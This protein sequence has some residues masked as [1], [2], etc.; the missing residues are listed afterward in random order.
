MVLHHDRS[1]IENLQERMRLILKLGQAL[2]YWTR[3]LDFP[4]SCKQIFQDIELSGKNMLEIGCGKGLFCIWASVQGANQVIGLEPLVKG[5]FDSS[6]IYTEFKQMVHTLEL[7]NID[8]LALRMQDYK[9]DNR[10]FDIVLSI[11]S[12][13][14]LDEDSCICLR[15]SNAAKEKYVEIFSNIADQMKEGAKLIILDCSNNNFFADIGLTNP[16]V[17]SIEWFKHQKP[18]LWAELLSDCGFTDPKITWPS[19]RYLRYMKTYNRSKLLSYF[20]D[21]AFRLEMTL[22]KTQTENYQET[23][24]NS[25][26]NT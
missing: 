10:Y 24:R 16:M 15:E 25:I 1:G 3:G 5:S 2:G 19:G 13:N 8:L 9:A 7:V 12:I 26:E 23:K 22:R 18:E 17:K 6:R 14:H 11:A 20:I 4:R 21:S